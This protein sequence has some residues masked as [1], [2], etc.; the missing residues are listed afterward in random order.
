MIKIILNDVQFVKEPPHFYQT[1]LKPISFVTKIALRE[2]LP[3][4][5]HIGLIVFF[6]SAVMLQWALSNKC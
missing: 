6:A 3:I 1:Y 5:A 4:R 2:L